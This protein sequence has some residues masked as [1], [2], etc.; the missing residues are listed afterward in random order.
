MCLNLTS[1]NKDPFIAEEDIVCYKFLRKNTNG[2]LISPYREFKY[3]LNEIVTSALLIE[4]NQF[5]ST[6]SYYDVD[7]VK[8]SY[9]STYSVEEGL[10]SFVHI[11]TAQDAALSMVGLYID[12]EYI[13]AKCIIPKYSMVYKGLFNEHES[14]ASNQLVITEILDKE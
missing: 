12:D 11:K 13:V 1:D 14:Y 2:T 10:H 3:K 7:G 9:T 4:Y 5:P 8:T 6:F